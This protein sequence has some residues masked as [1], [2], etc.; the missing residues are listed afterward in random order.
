MRDIKTPKTET[1]RHMNTGR[2]QPDPFIQMVR[3]QDPESL[4]LALH[5]VMSYMQLGVE[6]K[7]NYDSPIM[8]NVD[9]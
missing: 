2:A 1:Q 7:S 3:T 9:L 4:V 5:V 8:R 6:L